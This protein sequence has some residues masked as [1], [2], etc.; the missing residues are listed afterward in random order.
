ME[1]INKLKEVFG[2]FV[3]N[4]DNIQNAITFE[5]VDE[6]ERSA[7]DALQAIQVLVGYSGSELYAIVQNKRREIREKP[8]EEIISERTIDGGSS[9]NSE[10]RVS[11]DASGSKPKS[12]TKAK[13]T[14]SGRGTRGPA[15]NNRKSSKTK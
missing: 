10:A 15:K 9:D 2:A 12:T 3:T 4:L 11:S 5:E 14:N 6:L 8:I 7:V 13:R 1:S